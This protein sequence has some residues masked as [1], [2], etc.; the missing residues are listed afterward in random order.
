MFAVSAQTVHEHRTRADV[1]D[2]LGGGD[3][4]VHRQDDL[5]AWTD[6]GREICELQRIGAAA[7]AHRVLA[8]AVGRE[9]VFEL[10]E[11]RAHRVCG[12]ADDGLQQRAIRL[13]EQLSL[14]LQVDE[15]D[16]HLPATPWSL[17]APLG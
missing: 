7:H 17:P 2:G 8:V 12:P 11:L 9:L 3:E 6:A 15:R 13:A 1:R 16:M 10:G 5:V 14:R 4:R